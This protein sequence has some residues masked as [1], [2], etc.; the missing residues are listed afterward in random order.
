T[1]EATAERGL[2]WGS[3]RP[4]LLITESL[5]F[6]DRRT[7]DLDTE[8]PNPGEQAGKVG[9]NGETD[10]DQ[11]LLPRSG[12]FI[13]LYNPWQSPATNPA[14]VPG[15]GSWNPAEFYR[16]NRGL[17]LNQT[18]L[19]GDPMTLVSSPVWRIIV[20]RGAD[21]HHD[22]DHWDRNQRPDPDHVE[23]AIYF[24][25]DMA[26]IPLGIAN[27][28]GREQFYSSIEPAPLLPGR[29][30]VIGSSGYK[31]GAVYKTLI[32]RSNAAV[33]G[34][35]IGT[36]DYDNTR[37]I[38]L[39]PNIDP[40]VRDQVR[41]HNNSNPPGYGDPVDAGTDAQAPAIALPIDMHIGAGVGMLQS[42]SITEPV[43][44][45]PERMAAMA[46]PD[47][48]PELLAK[49]DTPLDN[50]YLDDPI[51][52]GD[53]D[54]VLQ[55]TATITNGTFVD[56]AVIHLQRLA[57]PLQ[58]YNANTNPYRTIDSHSVDVTAFNG[59]E[60]DHLGGIGGVVA[61]DYRFNAHQRGD[62]D[63]A[64]MGMMPVIGPPMPGAVQTRNLWEH[65]PRSAV[66]V[67][68]DPLNDTHPLNDHVF[69]RTLRTTLGF[70]NKPFGA[71]RAADGDVDD[72]TGYPFPLLQWNNRPF[73]SQL[74]LMLVPKSRSSRLLYEYSH[75]NSAVDVYDVPANGDPQ[76]TTYNHLLNFF[77]S[78]RDLANFHSVF[79]F[80]EVPSRFTGAQTYLNP[81]VF[82][83]PTK[84]GTDEFHPPFNAVTNY[85]DPGRINLNTIFDPIVFNGLMNGHAG[86]TYANWIDSRRGYGGGGT[87]QIQLHNNV[88][89]FFANPIRPAGSGDI[90]PL[91]HLERSDVELSLLRQSQAGNQPLFHSHY[92]DAARNATRNPTFKYQSLQRLGNLTTGRSNVYGVWITVGYFA[93]EPAGNPN[94]KRPDGYMLGAEIGVDQG[95][96]K[97]HRAFYMIDRSIPVASEPGE[98]HNVD[99][100]VILRRYVD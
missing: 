22:P 59:I 3:E 49:A 100:A 38:D 85:R 44:G 30:A 81:H 99:N 96:I 26:E 47:G 10:F 28:H 34:G 18:S 64:G 23:R 65:E 84:M 54:P 73:V 16:G 13:E 97:R 60:N 36:L 82:Q 83:D 89:T 79:N 50:Q 86:S 12:A 55:R 53:A 90:V 74:E 41:I 40:T 35:G 46:G 98:N 78:G 4:E 6:H 62:N 75:F 68:G 19:N 63:V 94:T 15:T 43:G 32:G 21:R 8:Q 20:V 80:T 1:V 7:E 29:Y 52:A 42:L 76:D 66:V 91:S 33:P 67:A 88:P 70:L 87:S 9:M 77:E 27:Y 45:Y 92:S 5:V 71:P 69:N 61:G 57:N 37:R 31:D 95:K 58:P 72:S 14:G 11:R 25:D 93:V 24:T 17:L 56:Y 2:V 51:H 39:T 48:E